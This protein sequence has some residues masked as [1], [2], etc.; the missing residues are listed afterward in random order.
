MTVKVTA[1]SLSCAEFIVPVP[2]SQMGTLRHRKGGSPSFK[3][4]VTYHPG[5]YAHHMGIPWVQL[6]PHICCIRHRPRGGGEGHR[7]HR[8][9][10][11]GHATHSSRA[12]TYKDTYSKKAW[13]LCTGASRVPKGLCSRRGGHCSPQ[14]RHTAHRHITGSWHHNFGHNSSPTDIKTLRHVLL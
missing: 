10:R 13:R 5:L 6:R 7:N 14:T 3:A 11:N 9:T 8:H 1:T 2:M 4:I 12:V